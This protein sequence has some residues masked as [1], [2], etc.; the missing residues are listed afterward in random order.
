MQDTIRIHEGWTNA[1]PEEVGFDRGQLRR[2]DDHYSSIIGNG[3]IQ[4]AS[5]IIARKGKVFAQRSLGSLRHE[6]GSA[7]LLPDSIRKIYSI[8]KV[9]TAVAIHQLVD[10]GKIFLTESVSRIL[11]EF[12]NDKHRN[13]TIFQLL[14]HTSGL[15]GDPGFY[16]EPYGLPWYEWMA[17]EA[18]KAYPHVNWLQVVISGPMQRMPGKEWIY[19]SSGYAV[20]GEIIARVS[21]KSYEQYIHDEILSP[22]GLTN[23]FFK[24]P[25]DQRNAVCCTN[26]WEK[27]E[28]YEPRE[29]TADMPNVAGN[30]LYSTL[31]DL[32]KFGQMMLDGGTGNGNRV[33]SKRSVELQTVNHLHGL[34]SR[35]WGNLHTDFKYGLGWSVD[36]FDL[37]SKGTFSHEGYGHCGL[38]VDP[39]EEL[40]FAF[41]VPSHKGFTNES[42]VTPRAIVWSG[43]E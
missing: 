3:T 34:T 35:G 10:R 33:L 27:K 28:V 8:T 2:L 43:L 38:Y 4:G 20:L 26:D 18:K 19:C 16:L 40:V 14:T 36:H 17:R 23:T 37:A 25:E 11:P 7:D 24:V 13:I 6:D 29:R 21:G 32:W 31:E 1:S 9:F 15:Q 30:G 39:V 42:V 5:Y 41:L 12:D 22:L